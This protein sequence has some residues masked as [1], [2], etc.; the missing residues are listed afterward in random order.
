MYSDHMRIEERSIALH[1]EIAKRL[2]S[3]RELV[4]VARKNLEQWIQRDG[5]TPPLTE[6]R[7]ILRQ[8]L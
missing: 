1:G 3:K 5:E 8:Q 6:W 2:H 7:R 4:E